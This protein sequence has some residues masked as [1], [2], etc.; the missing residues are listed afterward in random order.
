VQKQCDE[1]GTKFRDQFLGPAAAKAE[2]TAAVKSAG[3]D[4]E[5]PAATA[6]KSKE[7]EEKP[8]ARK[9]ERH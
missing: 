1:I 5:K 3:K 7:G 9:A 2:K 6:G 4:G 8:A